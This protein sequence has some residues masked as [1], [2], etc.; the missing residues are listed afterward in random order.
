MFNYN[1]RPMLHH[2]TPF[3]LNM[4]MFCST[5]PTCFYPLQNTISARFARKKEKKKRQF[6]LHWYTNVRLPTPGHAC[7]GMVLE[8]VYC[9]R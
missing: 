9:L 1:C 8:L 5:S 2:V 4:D 6:V 3:K 7:V